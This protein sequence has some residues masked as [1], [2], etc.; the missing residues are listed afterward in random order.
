MDGQHHASRFERYVL[1]ALA[2]SVLCVS[3]LVFIVLLND[4]LLEQPGY[5]WYERLSVLSRSCLA[6]LIFSSISA[7][8]AACFVGGVFEALRRGRDR[9][10][11]MEERSPW[12]PGSP[13]FQQMEKRYP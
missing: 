3:P 12:H 5:H 8:A 7:Y 4:I 10:E 6:F 1:Y 13:A 2:F 11:A 9:R